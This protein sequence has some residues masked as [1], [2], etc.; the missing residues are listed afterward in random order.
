MLWRSR[1]ASGAAFDPIGAGWAGPT[2]LDMND[3]GTPEILRG[4]MVKIA[5][6]GEY[7]VPPTIDDPA[8]LA[9]IADALKDVGYAKG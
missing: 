5:D 4:T 6:G 9:E 1:T 3:D 7:K 2:I 8:I